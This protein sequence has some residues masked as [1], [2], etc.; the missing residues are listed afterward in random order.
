MTHSPFWKYSITLIF[1]E[2]LHLRSQPG[3][4][5]QVKKQLT[6]CTPYMNLFCLW[7]N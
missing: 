7:A 5:F 2:A 3:F 1:K 4:S 6:W